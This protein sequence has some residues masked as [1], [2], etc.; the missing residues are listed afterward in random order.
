M[1]TGIFSAVKAG[2]KHVNQMTLS[3]KAESNASRL[4]G[5]SD[6]DVAQ[7][8]QRDGYNELP[9]KQQRTFVRIAAE[10]IREPMFLL[11]L[12]AG[13]IYLLLGDAGDALML[14]M[15]VVVSM[16]IT[17]FQARK[18]ERVLETL[19]DLS[20]PRARV[21]RNAEQVRI[22]GR[23]V[24]TGD[25]LVLEEG[26]RV[27]ADG[28][29]IECHD[30]LIDESLLTG[31]S[32]PVAKKAATGEAA[33]QLRAESA[34]TRVYS[35]SMIVQ[36]GGVVRVTATG[37]LTELGKIGKTLQTLESERSPLQREIG[38]LVKRFAL[39]GVL[40]SLLALVL[41]GWTRGDWLNG[42]LVGIALAMSVMPEEFTVILTV[43]MALGAWRM[44]K[45]HVLTRHTPVIEALGSA[46]V[47]CV[48]KTGTLTQNRMSV[49]AVVA[50]GRVF[51]V[52]EM[53]RGAV[54]AS[55]HQVLEAAVSASEI[56][57]FDPMEKAFHRCAADLFPEDGMARR[58]WSLVHDYP[59]TSDIMAMTHA[60]HVPGKHDYIVATKGAPEA[61][62]RLCKL[63][64]QQM[65][66]MLHQV[67]QLAAQGM[68]V[69]GVATA[70]FSGD[71]WPLTPEGFTFE[72]LGL[73]GLADPLRPEVPAAVNECHQAGIRVIMITGD[74]P[75]TAQ[76]IAREAGLPYEKV[77][78]G[79]E[80]A[81][82]D[83]AALGAAVRDVH[84]FA[85]IRPE[86]K[87]R[88]VNAFKANGDVVA[89]TGDG[90]NDAPA[91]KAAHIGIS[92]GMRGTDVARE[93]SSLVLLD[94]DF[95]SIVRTIRL[96]RTIYDN[97]RKALSY[98]VAVHLPIAGMVMLPLLFA[99]PMAFLPVHI[100]FLEMIINPAC[101]IVF[102][103]EQAE[104][105]IMTRPPRSTQARLFGARD[106]MLSILQGLG[107][108]AAAA[109][110]FLIGLRSGL[111][112]GQARA[113]A[114]AC[115]VFGNLS[116][117]ISSR[118]A[119]R[120]AIALLRIRNRAQWW[121]FAGAGAALAIVLYAPGVREVF[122]F[123]PVHTVD[124]LWPA[125]AAGGAIV[126]F[127]LMKYGFRQRESALLHRL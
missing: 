14:L 89:M 85:R 60:W 83:D 101:A 24:V 13:T 33:A 121:I 38:V 56:M 10:I 28:S 17:I 22:P 35:G 90:V 77:V 48:D 65:T 64:Q 50:E 61:V 110:V 8:L 91:L 100:V 72:W 104:R 122:H 68:R 39:F 111:T 71:A 12:A 54:P 70:S 23:E 58:A 7:R 44:A 103:A 94:D 120:S 123:A 21:I 37:T 40:L 26:D 124:L 75:A 69:L 81:A 51:P 16:A 109:A 27:P 53:P 95:T 73:V 47:L 113:L 62:G 87:L 3:G 119:V 67:Q 49:K 34:D 92:M 82:L 18:T 57:P 117:I 86:Q 74:Y 20:S 126:W 29:L 4:R 97:L 41:Y 96:G 114:F 98:V 115:V 105:D 63:D 32:L 108:L 15:F 42:L 1:G 45:H 6:Q 116:L 66:D 118:S 19:R 25:F 88:L 102:E 55:V 9:S 127:D 46:T 43:F 2:M 36:G 59:L 79:T 84:I 112:D 125:L 11:L 5:L 99:T 106:V 78:T 31:E 107:L 52:D 80:L 76:A 30:L 93:A